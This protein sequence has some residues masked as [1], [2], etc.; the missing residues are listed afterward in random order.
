MVDDEI[1]EV[2]RFIVKDGCQ[3]TSRD[4]AIE[5]VKRQEASARMRDISSRSNGA[6]PYSNPTFGEIY[7]HLEHYIEAINPQWYDILNEAG[8]FDAT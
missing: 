2:T 5:H 3:F 1:V 4:E 8:A 6:I 7:E